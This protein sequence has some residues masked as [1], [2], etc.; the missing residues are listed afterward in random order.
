MPHCKRKEVIKMKKIVYLLTVMGFA[1]TFGLAYAEDKDMSGNVLYNG[2]TYFEPTALCSVPGGLSEEGSGAGGMAA[3]EVS[4]DV[5]LING[6]T[7][8]ETGAIAR[9][10]C[11][12][13][14]E[15]PLDVH[16]GITIPGGSV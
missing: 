10:K 7:F 13:A 5:N 11:S 4:K 2:I 16:N 3:E 1:L 12:W 9:A 14:E 8:F 6:I 15:S